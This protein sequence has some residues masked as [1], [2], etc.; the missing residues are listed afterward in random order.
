[1]IAPGAS[2]KMDRH[3]CPKHR[4]TTEAAC[5]PRKPSDLCCPPTPKTQRT[6][7]TTLKT[8]IISS[9]KVHRSLSDSLSC[10]RHL[11]VIFDADCVV[12]DWSFPLVPYTVHSPSKIT[13]FKYCCIF[14]I[15]SFCLHFPNYTGHLLLFIN[16]CLPTSYK[17]SCCFV[18][19]PSRYSLYVWLRFPNSK[20]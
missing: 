11:L 15:G 16:S 13:I 12:V 4:T 8:F 7:K 6:E 9:F 5:K 17:V 20:F 18:L 10:R 1:M 19:P 14:S 3:D 2:S